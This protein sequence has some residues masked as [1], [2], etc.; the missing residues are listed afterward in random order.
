LA[1]WTTCNNTKAL[2]LNAGQQGYLYPDWTPFS[3][4]EV[5]KFIGIYIFQ[6]LSLSPQLRIKFKPQSIDLIN[7]NDLCSSVFG[8]NAKKRH[9]QFKCFFAVQN[10][11]LPTPSK[12]SHPK[13]KIYPFLAWVQTISMAAWDVGSHLSG[14]EQTIGFKANH[15]DKQRI[16]YK[17]EGDV[18]LAD[19]IA[20]DGYT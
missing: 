5:K 6:G 1:D 15:A 16:N 4:S 10:S 19:T 18:F 11:L 12:A 8:A 14:D 9:K 20:E 17:K 2:L 7:G 13:W 3:V